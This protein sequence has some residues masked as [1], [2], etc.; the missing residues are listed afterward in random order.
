MSK[1]IKVRVRVDGA[2]IVSDPKPIC[3]KYRKSRN[4]E[5]PSC[6]RS[7]GRIVM[8]PLRMFYRR[9]A[10]GMLQSHCIACMKKAATEAKKRKSSTPVSPYGRNI[11]LF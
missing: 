10:T 5:C 7:A 3:Q 9:G 6:S 8:H 1:Y 11:D 2:V 4:K